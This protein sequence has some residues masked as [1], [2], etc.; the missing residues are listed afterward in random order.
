[1]QN[2]LTVEDIK[3]AVKVFKENEP[4]AK[5]FESQEDVDYANLVS[6]ILGLEKKKK[7]GEEYFE[8]KPHPEV[9]KMIADGI[10]QLLSD[11]YARG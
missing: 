8:V 5:V 7:I 2:S 6:S 11:F 3:L 1:M 4:P 10:N 9:Q